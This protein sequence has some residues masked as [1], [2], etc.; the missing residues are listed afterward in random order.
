LSRSF[1]FDARVRRR[2]QLPN[3]VGIK[4]TDCLLSISLNNAFAGGRGFRG[5]DLLNAGR[6]SKNLFIAPPLLVAGAGEINSL[7]HGDHLFASTPTMPGL[8]PKF[9]GAI[10]LEMIDGRSAANAGL[11]RPHPG[12]SERWDRRPA[13]TCGAPADI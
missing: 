6:S 5:G 12:V 13:G 8:L 7:S 4:R 1:F 11:Q 3:L 9:L 2:A 10:T